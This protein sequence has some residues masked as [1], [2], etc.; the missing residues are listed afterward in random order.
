MEGQQRPRC[1]M[2]GQ[3]RTRCV[4]KGQ[5]RSGCV[6]KGQQRTTEGL[7]QAS[8]PAGL[9]NESHTLLVLTNQILG[10]ENTSFIHL[11]I[12]SFIHTHLHTFIHSFIHS[13]ILSF[14]HPL[15]TL[16]F[17]HSF[18]YSYTHLSFHSLGHFIIQ[19]PAMFTSSLNILYPFMPT[20]LSHILIKTFQFIIIDQSCFS[21]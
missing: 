3:Q 19:R 1:V 16:S 12:F 10:F 15:H 9:F 4:I 5:Q 14:I 18:I 2:K 7:G 17:N 21:T 20:R 8:A 13:V 6:M 11:V